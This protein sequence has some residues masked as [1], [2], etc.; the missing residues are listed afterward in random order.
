M[1]S[2]TFV[3]MSCWTNS[4]YASESKTL[5]AQIMLLLCNLSFCNWLLYWPCVRWNYWS[6]VDSRHKGCY[7]E[8][9]GHQWIPVARISGAELCWSR[10][11]RFH[12]RWFLHTKVQHCGALMF[13]YMFVRTSCFE[14]PGRSNSMT[15]MRCHCY[16]SF[17]NLLISHSA[18]LNITIILKG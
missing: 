17:V 13:S 5:D 12:R 11:R 1:S 8:T 10:L 16:V 9:T 7:N 2:L 3:R 15:R 14:L 18:W 4:G 6:P